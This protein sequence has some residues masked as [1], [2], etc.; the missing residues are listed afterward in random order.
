MFAF[1]RDWSFSFFFTA[2][3]VLQ[4]FA[5]EPPQVR[6]DMPYLLEA[7][8]VTPPNYQVTH[9]GESLREVRFPISTFLS[10]GEQRDLTQVLYQIEGP[11]AMFEVVDFLPKTTLDT[12]YAAP[13]HVEHAEEKGAQF[14][15]DLGGSYQLVSAAL[16]S[17]EL[18]DKTSSCVKAELLPPMEA[19]SSSGT[20]LRQRGVY[21]RLHN[22]PQTWL[23]GER[24]FA[25]LLRVPTDWR[26]DYVVVR[27]QAEGRKKG[28][29]TA[30]DETYTA[31]RRDFVVALYASGD[32]AARTKAVNFVRAESR[33]RH[34]VSEQQQAIER[35]GQSS[36]ARFG[37]DV[38]GD[39]PRIPSDWMPRLISGSYS[40]QDIPGRLPP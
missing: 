21:F 2:L 39:K 1:F 3:F 4:C 26:G 16:G 40:S 23:E 24:E 15:I 18:K 38:P 37:F 20:M 5:A 32:A 29:V 33:L 25:V 14:K 10:R 17:L 30:F 34:V 19:L 8:D 22:T 13:L 9:P 11:Q 6:F 12:R 36:L 31:G 27:C 35:S 7:R 28:M